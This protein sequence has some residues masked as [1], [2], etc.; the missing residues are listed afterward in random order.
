MRPLLRL[1]NGIRAVFR[2]GIAD[3]ELDAELHAFLETAVEEK[4]RGGLGREQA[5]RIARLEL[6]LV[7]IE[8]VKDRVRD[9]GWE[10]YV[11]SIWRDVRY[12]LRMLRKSPGF[13]A[14]AVLTLALGIGATTAI[15]SLLDA[16]ILKSLPVSKPEELVLVGGS[17]YPVFQA[18]REH[19]DLF[20]DL[21]ATSGVTPLDV[22]IDAGA[23]ERTN[24]SLVSG[25]YFSTLGVRAAMGRVF[26]VDDDQVPGGHPVAVASHGYWQRRFGGDVAALG[27]V[28]RIGGT[29]IAI[30][31][32]SRAGF[33]GEQVGV[34]PD[35]WIPL[36]MWGHVVPGPNY[37]ESPGRGWLRMIGRVRRGVTVSGAHPQLTETFRRVLT[38]TFGPNMGDDVRRDIAK[39]VIAV[40]PA[41]NGLSRL[42]TQFA[43]PLQVLLAAVVVVLLIACANIANLLLARATTRRREIDIR[44]ALGM[45]RARL[46]RQLLTESAVLA[47]LGGVAGLAVAWLGREGLLRLI[48]ADGSR[49][50]LA[51]ETDTRLLVF[52]AVVSSG[53]AILFG[54]APAWRA[55][56]ASLVTSL[57][58]RHETGHSHRLGSLLVVAQIAL[59]LILLTGAGLLLRTIA[60][61]REVDLGFAPKHLLV[62]DINPQAAGYAGDRAAALT[63][64]LLEGIAAQP[65][66]SAASLSEHGVLTGTDNGT[67][68]MRPEGFVADPEGF[69]PTRWDVVGPRYFSTL[70]IPLVAGRDFNERDGAASPVVVA[71]NETMAELFF[72]RSSAIGQRMVW[73]VGGVQRRF[74]VVAVARDVKQAGGREE[75]RPRFYVPYL[76]LPAVRPSWT[77]ASTRFL[78]RTIGDPSNVASAVREVIRSEDPRLSVISLDIAPQLVSRTLV[79]ERMVA[80]LLVAFSA[81]AVGLACLGLYGLLAYHVVQRTSEI[82]IRMALGAQ[83]SDVLLSTVRRSLAWIAAGIAVGIPLALGTSRVAQGL[84]FGLSANDPG[85]FIAATIVMATVGLL[86]ACI[87]ARRAS[88]IDLLVALRAE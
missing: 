35:L 36:T 3:E 14:A 73:E 9:V 60:N 64:R 2:R 11:E 65:G 80:I 69:P 85:T 6:G 31:G 8:S 53:T 76:Q 41:G 70:G 63:R 74:E 17:Q 61:L 39:A 42:R 78:V 4:M 66:V 5:T 12:A 27:R 59:S 56:R 54:L 26:T 62:A 43:R 33:F 83:P 25:S 88:R 81:L 23:R 48:S 1:L 30:V 22:E 71:I 57:T 34:A 84:L 18:F 32:V 51:V 67:D 52:V 37:L 45:D 47:A 40:E 58:T 72:A 50:P 79:Q 15:F 55:A 68:L 7:S 38:G 82:G 87:P 86:A 16:V 46:V 44:L 13:A 75:P 28:V 21:L 10:T 20:A 49:L 19:T 24:V 29:S 77:L